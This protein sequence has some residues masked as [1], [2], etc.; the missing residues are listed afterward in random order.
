MLADSLSDP[1]AGHHVE[2]L[3]ITFSEEMEPTRVAAAWRSTVAACAVLQTCFAISHASP[4]GQ[5]V[6]KDVPEMEILDLNSDLLDSWREADRRQPL[7]AK[8]CVPW[9]TAYWPAQRR[10]CWTFHHALLDGRS[11]TRILQVFLTYLA[12]ER[13]TKLAQSIWSPPSPESVKVATETLLRIRRKCPEPE[14]PHDAATTQQPAIRR[15]GHAFAESL[16]TRATTLGTTAATLVIGGW[17]HALTGFLNTDSVL[18]EQLRAGAPQPQTAGFTMHVLPLMIRRG[19]SHLPELRAD[20]LAM[21]RFET[22]SPDDF[23]RGIYP[24]MA[25]APVIMVEHSTLSHALR[26]HPLLETAKLRERPA[27]YSSASAFLR[28][29]L[30]MKVEGPHRHDLLARWCDALESLDFGIAETRT[31]AGRVRR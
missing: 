6:V 30:E 19:A 16:K 15:M 27:T 4:Q 24:D 11:I 21:R 14:W 18:V 2:Q 25:A 17:G 8:D 1:S 20:L 31:T 29:D 7:L 23:A 9:R 22:V 28:P 3:E 10:W 26:H 13:S 5:H 12:G